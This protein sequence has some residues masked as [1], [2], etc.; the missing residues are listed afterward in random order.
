MDNLTDTQRRACM[1]AVRGKDTLPEKA[2][3]KA[4]HALGY[5]FRVHQ[6]QLPGKPDIV[7]P[8]FRT[9]LFVHGCFW[10]GHDCPR[11]KRKPV[12]RAS[13]WERKVGGNRRRD[14][15]HFEDLLQ[16]G[17]NVI[18]VWECELY[19]NRARFDEYT[20]REIAARI[21]DPSEQKSLLNE[22]SQIDSRPH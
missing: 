10:H 17:W 9:V 14:R 22:H 20:A 4:L 2:V 8:R 5:R 13:Y 16:L 18:V 3:R 11:G 12:S 6:A 7:L 19:A 21:V 1:A 15:Q